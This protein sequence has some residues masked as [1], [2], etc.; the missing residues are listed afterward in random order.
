MNHDPQPA[1]SFWRSPTGLT[2]LVGIAVAG[3]YLLTEHTAHVFGAL[4]YLLVL[5]CPLMHVFMHRGHGHGAQHHAQ[6][7][8]SDDEQPRQ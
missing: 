6:P 3:F 5:A 8:S 7:R 1:P 4:P 2:L